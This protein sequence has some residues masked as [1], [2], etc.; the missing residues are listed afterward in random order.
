M[1]GTAPQR[2]SLGDWLRR[3]MLKAEDPDTPKAAPH[4][5]MSV[6]EAR[7]VA[8]SADDKERLIGLIAAPIA[9]GIG[10]ITTSTL[11]SNDPPA[12]LANGLLNHHHVPVA[13]YHELL[14]ALLVLGLVMMASAWF[15]KRLFLAISLALYGLTLFNMH[16]W[17]FGIPYLIA[18]S[19]LLVRS[20]RVQRDL[21]MASDDPSGYGRSGAGG[22]ARAGGAGSRAAGNKRYTPRTASKRPS[23]YRRTG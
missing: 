12:L 6:E 18:G 14:I 2:G 22:S 4:P 15:R 20:Y 8:R 19:W 10:L 7:A 13:V 21:R 3:T 9:A 16:Y 5:P 11:I 1:I 17:G 23:R